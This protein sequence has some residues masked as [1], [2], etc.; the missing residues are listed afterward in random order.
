MQRIIKSRYVGPAILMAGLA[1]FC[2]TMMGK[3]EEGPAGSFGTYVSQ[4]L[5]MQV[6]KVYTPVMN[7]AELGAE[8]MLEQLI[9]RMT[10]KIFP[11][12]RY[13]QAEY[14]DFLEKMPENKSIPKEK[15]S[16]VEMLFLEE[17]QG[18]KLLSREE[19][20]EE[21]LDEKENTETAHL[22]D[23]LMAEFVP[24]QEKQQT[25][26]LGQYTAYE[27]LIKHFYTID[28]STMVGS[29]Q[30]EVNELDGVEIHVSKEDPGPQILIY[31]THSQE[32]FADSVSGDPST[33]IVGVGEY[34]TKLLTEVYGYQ[35]L[36]HTAQYD[37]PS[38]DDAYA[39]ALPE[40]EK[41]ISEYPQIQVVIDL[42]RDA[43]DESTRLV[44]QLNGRPTAR[45]MFF[46][47]VSRTR[48]TGNISYL[49]NENLDTNL[50]F[51]FQMQKAA[52]EYYP[53][54]TRK[55]YLKAYRYN[56]H[57]R[58]LDLLIELGAQNNTVEEAMNACLPLAHLLDLVLSGEE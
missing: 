11:L 18:E 46:N 17:E 28:K 10:V 39:K 27:T 29:D 9:G 12:Y 8:S 14:I 54:L 21:I 20:K 47:G 5:K 1:V 4:M 52:M 57:L 30:L 26:D 34:L 33:T 2:I 42:H 45:F 53:G 36:H 19:T 40:L 16:T 25:V 48:K 6:Q 38:R 22:L 7:R 23:Q 35:V 58:P 31:H 43:M 32:A 37:V 24:Q 13:C 41:L 3:K 50:A 49:P 51:S 55:I 44:T 15:H 56:M